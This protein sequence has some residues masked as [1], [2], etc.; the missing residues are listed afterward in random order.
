MLFSKLDS[1]WT[2]GMGVL[3]HK[4][5]FLSSSD[6]FCAGR[7]PQEDLDRTMAACGGTVDWGGGG[8]GY[9]R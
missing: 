2:I 8:G 1:H 3:D 7:I 9:G 4:L 5:T 6:M